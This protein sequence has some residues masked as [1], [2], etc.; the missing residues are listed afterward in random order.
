MLCLSAARCVLDH[1]RLFSGQSTCTLSD[2]A[3]MHWQKKNKIESSYNDVFS[4]LFLTCCLSDS[5]SCC[6]SAVKADASLH[7]SRHNRTTSPVVPDHWV[8]WLLRPARQSERI[9]GQLGQ[10]C[11]NYCERV[12]ALMVFLYR[13]QL[14]M[15]PVPGSIL[16]T[17]QNIH[18]EITLCAGYLCKM[19]FKKKCI[20]SSCIT[21]LCLR[22]HTVNISQ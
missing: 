5:V 11:G 18:F 7:S 8:R 21:I 20:A 16:A 12:P 22:S 1:L 13:I 17:T 9:A 3:P 14:N 10:R 19:V 2:I 15:R 6:S 4:P